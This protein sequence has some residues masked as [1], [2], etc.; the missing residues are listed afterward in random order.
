MVTH[1][2]KFETDALVGTLPNTVADIA[3]QTIGYTLTQ[4]LVG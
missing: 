1:W 4:V 2:P 3:M